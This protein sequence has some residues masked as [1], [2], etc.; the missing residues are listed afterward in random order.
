VRE[1]ERARARERERERELS[2][3]PLSVCVCVCVTSVP[4]HT[5]LFV[6]LCARADAHKPPLCLQAAKL[7]GKQPGANKKKASKKNVADETETGAPP[8][9]AGK[10]LSTEP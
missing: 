5:C 4:I 1:R 2:S 7:D 10:S 6:V 9:T 8:R 3:A